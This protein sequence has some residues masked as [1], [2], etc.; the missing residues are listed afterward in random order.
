VTDSS[1]LLQGTVDAFGQTGTYQFEYGSTD[2]YGARTAAQ[3]LGA[4][5]QTVSAPIDG[6]R[7]FQTYH[8]RLLV[9]TGLGTVAGPDAELTTRGDVRDP[10]VTIDLPSCTRRPAHRSCHGWRGSA[11]AWRT[12]GG[13]AFDDARGFAS[14]VEEVRVRLVRRSAKTCRALAGRVMVK[15]SCALA[16]RTWVVA[17]RN[18]R[19]WMLDLPRLGRGA[20]QLT[21]RAS[22]RAGNAHD[23]TRTLHIRG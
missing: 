10:K 5:P 6:L 18:Q 13:T 20:Y 7:P 2:A 8:Y 21:V 9:T 12:L 15:R 4:G 23:A 22:D 3:P 19:S 17:W 14:G 16:A 1:A 11:A